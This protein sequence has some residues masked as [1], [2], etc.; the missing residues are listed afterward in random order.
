MT[1]HANGGRP[2]GR[3]LALGA[4]GA[5]AV[6]LVGACA[7]HT[8]QIPD[9]RPI[10]N[11]SGARIRVDKARMDSINQWVTREQ[12]NITKDPAFMIVSNRT[13][14]D[15]YP[16]E[17]MR[18]SHD[19]AAV[20]YNA[21]SPESDLPFEIYAHLH[22]MAKMGRL[23]EFLP[24]AANATGFDLERA[25]LAKVAD[26][27]LLARTVYNAAPY[28][29]LDELVYAKEDGYLDAFIFTARPDHFADARRKWAEENPDRAKEYRTWFLKTFNREPPGLRAGG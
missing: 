6:A 22:L 14:N 11:Y 2:F 10:I 3:R 15:V 29:P 13:A 8:P 16:W 7:G 19:T 26:A 12:D 4:L 27:W 28:E 5:L 1:H 21:Q 9:P 23:G 24:Q 20:Y 25:I 18:I 17:H